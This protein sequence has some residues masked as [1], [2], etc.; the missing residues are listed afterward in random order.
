M[1]SMD[2][3]VAMMASMATMAG[4]GITCSVHGKMRG[5]SSLMADGAGG[6]QCKPGMECKISAGGPFMGMGGKGSNEQKECSLHGKMRSMQSLMDNGAGGFQCA[7]GME[8]KVQ[9]KTKLCTFWQEGMCN[10]G[11]ACRF[12]HG[13]EEIGQPA[14]E[15]GMKGFKGKKGKMAAVKGAMGKGGDMG[16]FGGAW[17]SMFGGDDWSGWSGDDMW[18]GGWGKGFKGKAGMGMEGMGK[19]YFSPY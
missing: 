3:M 17:D 9:T 6:F 4:S 16:K 8:C 12:A 13:D 18:G 5:M 1:E 11:S 7:P 2:P 19:G 14:P 10:M 15:P